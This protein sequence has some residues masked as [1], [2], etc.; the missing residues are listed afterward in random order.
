[1]ADFMRGHRFHH[2]CPGR[3]A[4]TPCKTLSACALPRKESTS[5]QR[6]RFVAQRQRHGTGRILRLH[7]DIDGQSLRACKR[8][9][10]LAGLQPSAFQIGKLGGSHGGHRG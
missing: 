8:D 1:M 6:P 5:L 10:G 9:D 7:D 2:P 3:A 4:G